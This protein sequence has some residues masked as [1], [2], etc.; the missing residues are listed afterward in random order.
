MIIKR[1]EADSVQAGLHTEGQE[2]RLKD[3]KKKEVLVGHREKIH[4]EKN[5]NVVS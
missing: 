4:S 3:Q 2:A 5:N 1:I